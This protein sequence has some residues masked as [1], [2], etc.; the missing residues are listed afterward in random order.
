MAELSEEERMKRLGYFQP[1]KGSD[2][3]PAPKQIQL[4]SRRARQVELDKN[5]IKGDNSDGNEPKSSS[6]TS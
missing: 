1:G 6:R 2:S 4:S 5:S 3:F